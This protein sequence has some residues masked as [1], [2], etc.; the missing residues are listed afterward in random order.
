MALESWGQ[1]GINRNWSLAKGWGMPVRATGSLAGGSNLGKKKKKQT[2]IVTCTATQGMLAGV[3]RPSLTL[4]LPVL[5]L[6]SERW[7]VETEL[8]P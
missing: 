6:F 3:L 7:A 5:G 2:Q 8:P 1:R 4:Y